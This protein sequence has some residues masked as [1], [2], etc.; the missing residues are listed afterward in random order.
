MIT[1]EQVNKQI[2]K[3]PSY[4]I[5]QLAHVYKCSLSTQCS[6]SERDLLHKLET[7]IEKELNKRRKIANVETIDI[8]ACN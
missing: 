7:A 6:K 3:L 2:S 5:E 8:Q 1:I 4:N